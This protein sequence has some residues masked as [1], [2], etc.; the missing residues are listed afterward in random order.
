MRTII[1]KY[2]GECRGC[3]TAIP[4]GA[5][6]IHER[7][8]GIFCP[9]CAPADPEAVRAIR[10][11][12][13]DRRAERY[14][15]WAA[16]RRQKAGALEARNAPYRGDIAFATQPGHIPERARVIARTDK[17]LEHSQKA[18]EF[19]DRARRLRRGVRV[20]GDA[21]KRRQAV[22]DRI[23]A[24][25]KVGMRVDTGIYGQGVVERINRKTA[26][27]GKTGTSG[28]YRTTVDL[29]FLRLL[30]EVPA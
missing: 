24:L 28:T 4:V 1:V 26:T 11:E 17:A 9:P 12:A 13:A 14:E 16:G 27:V 7:R 25:L 8:V 19:A 23:R 21:E 20:A 2:A 10:Q 5:A 6:A 15:G 18:D 30:E 3:G 22:R 29:S